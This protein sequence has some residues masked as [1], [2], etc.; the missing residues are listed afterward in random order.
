MAPSPTIPAAPPLK[1][2]PPSDRNHFEAEEAATVAAV[3]LPAD[4]TTEVAGVGVGVA[5][6]VV[7]SDDND[8]P[9]DIAAAAGVRVLE[10]LLLL[11][12]RAASPGVLPGIKGAP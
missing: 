2:A 9:P 5:E 4:T 11:L 7:G 1:E 8:P 6:G 12:S 10:G 3:M